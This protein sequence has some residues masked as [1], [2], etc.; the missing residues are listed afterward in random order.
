MEFHVPAVR[1][2][3]TGFISV[4]NSNQSVNRAEKKGRR[5]VGKRWRHLPCWRM[6]PKV[7]VKAAHFVAKW[8]IVS[9]GAQSTWTLCSADASAVRACC[10]AGQRACGRGSCRHKALARRTARVH[11]AAL[12][13]ASV[14]HRAGFECLAEQEFMSLVVSRMGKLTGCV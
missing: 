13:A 9:G 6:Q 2:T 11:A 1:C 10:A 3:S 8:H 14:Q 5:R 4:Q 12:S 7:C